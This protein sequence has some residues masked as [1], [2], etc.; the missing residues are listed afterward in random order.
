MMACIL[1]AA[2]A[3]YFGIAPERINF[4]VNGEYSPMEERAAIEEASR[5]ADPSVRVRRLFW[6]FRPRMRGE[7]FEKFYHHLLIENEREMATTLQRLV[8]L[9]VAAQNLDYW[10]EQLLLRDNMPAVLPASIFP[11]QTGSE[12]LRSFERARSELKTQCMAFGIKPDTLDGAVPEVVGAFSFLK[13]DKIVVRLLT[14]LLFCESYGWPAG[15]DCYNAPVEDRI[16]GYFVVP[17]LPGMPEYSA[18]AQH[19]NRDY[20][21]VGELRRWWMEH[22]REFGA[23]PPTEEFIQSLRRYYV[24]PP[25]KEGAFTRVARLLDGKP[26]GSPPASGASDPAAETKPD[27][28]VWGGVMAAIVLAACVALWRRFFSSSGQK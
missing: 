9:A 15:E 2:R 6:H 12:R 26:P 10:H 8:S 24:P 1:A 3:A 19:R 5:I 27:R 20:S 16:V 28:S 18:R 22:A 14:P 23:E 21:F 13:N 17:P 4:D 7:N 11:G 25:K